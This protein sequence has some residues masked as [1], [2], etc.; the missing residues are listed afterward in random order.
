[1]NKLF[2]K[3]FFLFFMS[4][5]THAIADVVHCNNLYVADVLVE[6]ARDDKFILSNKL[7]IRVKDASGSY[8]QCGGRD[9]LHLENTSPAYNGM[10]SIA[11]AAHASK[12]TVQI[13]IN[14]NSINSHSNQIAFIRVMDN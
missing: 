10:L 14:T 7:A 1:M 5:S 13:A 6:G 2:F 4:C 9:Y 12:K 11:L 3:V 8:V